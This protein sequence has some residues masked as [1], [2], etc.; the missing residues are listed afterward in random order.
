MSYCF[1]MS[2]MNTLMDRW[3][4]DYLIYAPKRMTG[5]G[6]FSDVDCIRYGEVKTA[7]EIVFDEKSDYS[8]KEILTPLSQ[9]LF[10]FTEDQVS[11]P[12]LPDKNVIVFLRA[13]DLNA[14]KRMDEIYLLNGSPDAYYKRLRER[15]RFMLIGCPH[16]FESCFCV[17][18]EANRAEN[19]DGAVSLLDGTFYLN[20]Q[21]AEWEPLFSQCAEGTADTQPAFVTE[22]PTHV[23]IPPELTPDV[24]KSS[25]WDEYDSRCIDCGRCTYV[26]PTCTCFTMQDL[27]YTDNGKVGERRR[28]QASCMVD[29]FTDVAGGG[30]YRQKNGQRMRFK[31]LHK[32]YDFKQRFGYQMCIGCG[33]CDD[34]CPEYISFSHII[35][36]LG[37]MMKEVDC[38]AAK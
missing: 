29:G 4:K 20:C 6:T 36:R 32:V 9:T 25:Q 26:C 34:I 19:Y 35:N 17:D 27:F 37:S 3:A 30:S 8:F 1:T 18:M 7:E 15:L 38:D 11:Q 10:Y 13:C 23:E 14:V 12:E 33:R 5:G 22:N 2:G 28:V 21:L 31:T 16:S 24:M